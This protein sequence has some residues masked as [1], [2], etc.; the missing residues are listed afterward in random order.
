MDEDKI[1]MLLNLTREDAITL[2]EGNQWKLYKSIKQELTDL[3]NEFD[4]IK[5]PL[6]V[7]QFYDPIERGP[8]A[9]KLNEK[10]EAERIE[11]IQQH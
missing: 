6:H 10:I 1:K 4:D 8:L 7:C 3:V 11:R 9:S 2:M 5:L